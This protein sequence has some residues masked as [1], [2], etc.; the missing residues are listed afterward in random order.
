MDDTL[1]MLIILFIIC[2]IIYITVYFINKNIE[3]KEKRI[4][5]EIKRKKAKEEYDKFQDIIKELKSLSF[6]KKD[7]VD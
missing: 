1:L 7:I 3:N 6:D 2:L 4:K 5:D